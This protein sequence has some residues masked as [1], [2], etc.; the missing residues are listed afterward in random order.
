MEY[1]LTF[2][3]K[4]KRNGQS[5]QVD[6]DRSIEEFKSTPL[7]TLS[8]LLISPSLQ[9]RIMVLGMDFVYNFVESE[10]ESI[11]N[12][13]R[14]I[15]ED[16]SLE[17][18]IVPVDIPSTSA[19]TSLSGNEYIDPVIDEIEYTSSKIGYGAMATIDEI[20]PLCRYAQHCSITGASPSA[21]FSHT[22]SDSLGAQVALFRHLLAMGLID[23]DSSICDLTAGRGD[24][25]YAANHLGLSCTSFSLEDTFTKVNYHPDIV[26]KADY[27]VFDG[28]TL[29]FISGYD[30]IHVDI[31]FTGASESNLLDLIMF[32]EENNLAYSIRLNSTVLRGYEEQRVKHLPSYEHRIAYAFNQYLKPYQIYLVGSPHLADVNW[33]SPPLRQTIA[34][35]SLAISFSRLLAPSRHK[36]RLLKWEPNSASIC[37]PDSTMTSKFV[38]SIITRSTYSERMYYCER[39]ISEIGEGT[40]IPYVEDC[41]LEEMRSEVARYP[42]RIETARDYDLKGDIDVLIGS[43]SSSSKKF[44]RKHLQA[45]KDGVQK[46]SLIS[47][48]DC[49]DELLELWRSRHPLSEC[50][51]WCNIVIGVKAFAL[52]EALSGFD[53]I[54]AAYENS[55][56]SAGPK[57]SLHQ[58]ELQQAIK[59]LLLSARNG[60]FSYGINYLVRL[61]AQKSKST[62]SVIRTL[63]C[64]RLLSYMYDDFI[65]LM[66]SGEVTVGQMNAMESETVTREKLKYKYHR[67]SEV[68]K[69][70]IEDYSDINAVIEASMD[71]LFTG[72]ESYALAMAEGETVKEEPIDTTATVSQMDLTFD[73]GIQN[74][75]EMMIAKL[76]LQ[77]S[78]AY[79]FIDI[80]DD[81]IGADE[82]W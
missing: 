29:K 49:S 63:R 35:K 18:I 26:H 36:D 39:Y 81:M 11:R 50:R 28:S 13:L 75:V 6:A 10:A 68:T 3:F 14:E 72:L 37:F 1:I 40:K 67:Q 9:T 23:T 79:G 61:M 12:E 51:S 73:I 76:G 54:K 65:R 22:G 8:H 15:C 42:D 53:A 33:E 2:H 74:Q 17:D 7:G 38:K 77:E 78:S 32:L 82:D 44:H 24:G 47:P 80:G 19:V 62:K 41:L 55:K 66:R 43:V 21:F 71:D 56:A 60:D 4:V 45:M 27:D 58:R 70:T 59:L 30:F 20:S 31:S 25:K 52:G 34:F 5:I 16:V 46:V 48:L 64:Y 57:L 69:P